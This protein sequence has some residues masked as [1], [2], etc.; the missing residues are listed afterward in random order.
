MAVF[1]P[2]DIGKD[3]DSELDPGSTGMFYLTC[4]LYEDLDHLVST[5]LPLPFLG[6]QLRHDR[7]KSSIL[8]S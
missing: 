5:P 6:E 4:D 1:T 2:T 3:L 7:M 8:S